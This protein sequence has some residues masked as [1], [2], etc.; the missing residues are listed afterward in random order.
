MRK[1][2][3][4]ID[5]PAGAGKSSIS[6]VVANKLGYLYIDTGAMYRSVTWAVLHDGIDPKDQ[7]AVEAI[8]PSLELRMEP[9]ETACKV[10]VRGQDITG[11]IRTPEVNQFVSEVA[12]HKGVRCYLVERQRLMA[13]AGGVILDG[14]DIGSVVLPD[15]ELKVYLTASVEARANR[16]YLE[17]KDTDPT[18]TLAS[19][20]ENV[21]HRDYLDMNREESPLVCVDDAV[22]VDSSDLTF[23]QTVDR[24]IGLIEE[25]AHE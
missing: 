12:A 11:A 16:R 9:T 3:V 19:I 14:R 25:A 17:V 1:I 23:E 22:V 4:A 20:R 8:L 13:K 10:F 21:E 15:A 2:A 7:V 6:K 5:G 24:L 18:I